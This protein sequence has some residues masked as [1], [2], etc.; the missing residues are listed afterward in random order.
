MK[1][2]FELSG[3]GEIWIDGLIAYDLLFPLQFYRDKDAEYWEFVK[4]IEATKDDFKNGRV[5][6]C[7]RRLEGYWP[8]FYTAYTPL[9]EPRMAS[10]AIRR[11]VPA[12]PAEPL[13][14]SSPGFGEK[15]RRMFPFDR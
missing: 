9:V 6:D 14:E 15:I 10:Q 13:P 3:A 2:R 4:L 11:S 7:V 1:V 8:R 12:P 5:T